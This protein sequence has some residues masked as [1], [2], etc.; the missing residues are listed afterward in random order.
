MTHGK[1]GEPMD[2]TVTPD[3]AVLHGIA[4]QFIE[5]TDGHP[6]FEAFYRWL[7]FPEQE[8]QHR[9]WESERYQWRRC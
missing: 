9:R 8:A 6:L 3:R 5:A 7:G 4:R 1:G 2:S